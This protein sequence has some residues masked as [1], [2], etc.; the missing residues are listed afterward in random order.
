MI[1]ILRNFTLE[2]KA[3]VELKA[4][5]EPSAFQLNNWGKY[6]LKEM[7]MTISTSEVISVILSSYGNSYMKL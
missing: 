7:T 6:C 4:K 5:A 3:K 1:Y 2:A